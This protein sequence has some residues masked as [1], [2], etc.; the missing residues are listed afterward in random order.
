MSKSFDCSHVTNLAP[1]LALGTAAGEERAAALEHLSTCA[2][3]RRVVNE[4]SALTDEIV[5][6]A[7]AHEPPAGFENRVLDRLSEEF[8]RRRRRWV[9]PAIAAALGAVAA[10]LALLVAFDD[11]RD[12]AS[13]YRRALDLAH[14]EYFGVRPL[15]GD[16]QAQEGYV[17][18]YQG[19]PS[20]FF[21]TLDDS[22]PGPYR[23]TLEMRDGT[24]VDLGTFELEEGKRSWGT[25]VTQD[26]GDV[27]HLRLSDLEG[28]DVLTAEIAH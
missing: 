3:C 18:V 22:Q 4:L 20:W 21:L 27:G 23:V 14:G 7:P 17:F 28:G 10:T 2:S 12:I 15:V 9:G 13:Q 5:A 8:P 24:D 16:E 26:T 25:T 19:S 6:L 1:E 11:D